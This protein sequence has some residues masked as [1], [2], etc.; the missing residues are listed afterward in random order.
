MR[1]RDLAT[2]QGCLGCHA[3]EDLVL[4]GPSWKGLFGK[5]EQFEDGSAATVDEAYLIQS[6]REPAAKIVAGFANTMPS[7][8]SNLPQ[9]DVDDI[10]AFI[11]ELE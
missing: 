9:Q 11:K 3:T 6:I 5:T 1:G 7:T 10:I 4:V 8:F 2:R